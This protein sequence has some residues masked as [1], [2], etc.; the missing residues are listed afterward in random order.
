MR[1]LRL[2]RLGGVRRAKVKAAVYRPWNDLEWEGV[3]PMEAAEKVVIKAIGARKSDQQF[4]FVG[5][6]GSVMIVGL[7]MIVWIY[8]ATGG[9]RGGLTGKEFVATKLVERGGV[10]WSPPS[11]AVPTDMLQDAVVTATTIAIQ[12]TY[13]LQPTYTFQPTY[14]LQATYTPVLGEPFYYSRYDPAL[15]DVEVDLNVDGSCKNIENGVCHTTNCWDYDLVKGEC[16]SMM[17]SGL[18]WRNYFGK[19]LACGSEYPLYTIFR[20]LT[21]TQLA[22]DYECLD[23]CPACT[24]KKILDFLSTEWTLNWMYPISVQVILR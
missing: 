19:A 9:T 12:S 11:T 23:R 13:T 2:R 18:D 10:G 7:T 24:G 4:N 16:R 20:V 21:P 17:T 1:L 5:V 22:G 15:V 8:L 14:T 6:I 3:T